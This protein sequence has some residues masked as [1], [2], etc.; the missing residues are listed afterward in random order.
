MSDKEHV[1]LSIDRDLVT[2]MRERVGSLS[3]FCEG[4][5][6]DEIAKHEQPYDAKAYA[7]VCEL[8]DQAEA[9]VPRFAE[10]KAHLLAVKKSHE[11]VELLERFDDVLELRDVTPD[12]LANGALAMSIVD[13]IR[14]K[15]PDR[16]E[17]QRCDVSQIR[18]YVQ[19]RN[20]Y[21]KKVS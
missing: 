13:V 3:E 2:K 21:F 12:K 16:P 1:N 7:E 20:D 15:Y 6:R 5:M 17:M 19:A 14:A 9:L 18:A 10:A 8:L 11:A 4:A